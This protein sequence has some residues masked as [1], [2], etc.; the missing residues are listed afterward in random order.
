[1][2]AWYGH[3]YNFYLAI[4]MGHFDI[5]QT[6]LPGIFGRIGHKSKV[7]LSLALPRTKMCPDLWPNMPT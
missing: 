4:D 1:M 5:F 6:L 7:I 2:D 3:T